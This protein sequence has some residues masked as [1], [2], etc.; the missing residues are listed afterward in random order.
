[1]WSKNYTEL[2]PKVGEYTKQL[3]AL[4]T[5]V[6]GQPDSPALPLPGWLPLRLPRYPNDAVKQL[7]KATALAPQDD[8]T[9]KLLGQF[10]VAPAGA[11]NKPADKKGDAALPPQAKSDLPK[12]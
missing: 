11:D 5:A 3:R 1:M 6:K 4:E 8:L 12:F 10:Q 9:K 2:Y 7:E